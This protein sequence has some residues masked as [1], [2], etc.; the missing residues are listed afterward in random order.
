MVREKTRK[1][2]REI[3]KKNKKKK[4]RRCKKNKNKKSKGEKSTITFIPGDKITDPTD[5]V[6]KLVSKESSSAKEE[7]VHT[8]SKT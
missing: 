6:K 4:G 8:K 3:K 5:L 1:E 2:R 7:K